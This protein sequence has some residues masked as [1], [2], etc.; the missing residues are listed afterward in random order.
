MMHSQTIC[1]DRE[2]GR[3]YSLAYE[4]LNRA[5]RRRVNLSHVTPLPYD[6]ARN[7]ARNAG[8]E[9]LL[10]LLCEERWRELL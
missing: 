5:G 3:I 10:P 1:L 4:P 6:R 8:H 9:E 2:T 7:L